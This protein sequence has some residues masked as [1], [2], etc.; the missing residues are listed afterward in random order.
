[1]TYETIRYETE[2]A[3]A[4]I[5]L[6]RPDKLNAIVPPMPEEVEAALAAANADGAVRVV[7][8]QGAGRAFCAGFDFGENLSH[9]E[10]WGLTSAA[11]E[12]DPGRDMMG[13][14]NPFTGP[15]PKFM[16]IWRSPKPVVAKIHGWCVGGGSEVGLLAD[17]VIAADDARLGT[18]YARVWGCHLTGMWI[19]RL[20]LT[21]AKQY[22]LTGDS[23]SG[24][25]A[26][27][28]GLVNFS[29][30]AEQLEERVRYWAGRM[31]RIP[32]TQLAAMKLIT[33]QAFENMGIHATQTLGPILD[34]L[35]RNTPEGREFVRTAREKGVAS[36]IAG[37]DEPFGDY[38]QGRA[39]LKPGRG[40]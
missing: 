26:A 16:S 22:A 6:N 7:I 21:R 17:L 4:V 33:N 12:W 34:G 20:G 10:S 38:S 2:G 13:V 3:L 35:M 36:A 30:P 32:V 28:I 31:A 8:L 39:G 5:T 9:F 29:Y 18:P 19:Y 15:I 27:E 25:E 40:G 24:K 11:E 37:R 1:M 23:L 14:L